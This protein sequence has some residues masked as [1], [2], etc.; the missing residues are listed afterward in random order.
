MYQNMKL[1]DPILLVLILLFIFA[2]PVADSIWGYDEAKILYNKGEYES[3]IATIDKS[4]DTNPL[5]IEALSLK[6]DILSAEGKKEEAIDF[7]N[8]VISID[9][10]D[11]DAWFKKGSTYYELN[12]YEK[13][14]ES[15]KELIRRDPDNKAAY[16]LEANALRKKAEEGGR[17]VAAGDDQQ[18]N[19]G[20]Y[21]AAI[22]SYD[23]AIKIDQN[24]I[25]A[26]NNKGI[27]LGEL[28]RFAESIACFEEA[29]RINSS[30]AEGWNNKGVSLDYWAK[31]QE[32]MDCYD[33]AIKINPLLA[34]AWY[35]KANTL[36]L[37]L[38]D[39]DQ[40]KEYYNK[41][42]KL[43]PWFKGELMTWVY[44]EIKW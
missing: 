42:I 17:P 29:I 33:E 9:P 1:N 2:V 19:A 30:F 43:A 28:S 38:T 21:E 11:S 32:S 27:A 24:Y 25:S 3:A 18:L 39:Y 12:Q 40:A 10:S 31:H 35:N 15:S 7:Y 41:S 26:W 16:N 4:I 13:A 8:K 20:V 36:A 22:A 44:V 37:N 6:G 23:K 14:I 34:E 5:N